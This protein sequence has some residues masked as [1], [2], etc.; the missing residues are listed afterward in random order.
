[1]MSLGCETWHK[2]V[3]SEVAPVCKSDKL[4]LLRCIPEDD[5]DYIEEKA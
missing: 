5:F 1:M 2:S 4:P 3:T